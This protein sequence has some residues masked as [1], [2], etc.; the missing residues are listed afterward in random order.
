MEESAQ[1]L[2]GG[3]G[4]DIVSTEQHKT[5]GATALFT[6]QVFGCWNSLLIGCRTGVKHIFFQL[7][8]FVLHWIEQQAVQ[9][10]KYR[11]SRFARNRSPA[12]KYNRHLVLR[13]QL[14]RFFRKQRPVGGWVND[15]RF[16]LLA[17]HAAM[18][19]DVIDRH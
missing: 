12:A 10:F 14:S 13:N 11:Q 3:A 17:H 1:D 2:V 8:T 19:V 16:Q 6:H 4:I 9:F 5:L 7:F 15:D 18:G